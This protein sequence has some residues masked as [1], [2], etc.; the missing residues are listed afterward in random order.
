MVPRSWLFQGLV[1][2]LSLA[3]GYAIGSL[4]GRLVQWSLDR[5][6]RSPGRSIRRWAWTLVGIAWLASLVVG[7]ALWLGWQDDLVTLMGMPAVGWFDAA[8]AVT[9]SVVAGIVLIVVGRAVVAG[10][11]GLNG[12]VR[13]LLP[14]ELPARVIAPILTAAVLAVGLWI[15]FR[16]VGAVADTVYASVNDGTTAGTVQPTSPAVSGSSAS[17]VSWDSLG[18]QG[19]DFVSTATIADELRSFHGNRIAE[20]VRVYVG[21]RSAASMADRAALAVRE[22]ERAGGFD[23]A[24]LVVWIP[25][26]TGWVVPEAATSLE[27]VYGGDTAIVA[28]QYSYLPSLFSAFLQPGVGA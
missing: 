18:L 15:A 21:I 12:L 8:A 17:L 4:A 3:I 23:R 9:L 14:G 2:G 26:G 7:A 20:P 6:G 22:L 24:V 25:T 27:Q 13:R 1:G 11:R 5:L 10:V 28:M 19:R 16:G